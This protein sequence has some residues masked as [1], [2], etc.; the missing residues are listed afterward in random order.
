MDGL[1]MKNSLH[2]YFSL[3]KHWAWMLILVTVLCGGAS[4][5]ISE[6]IPP[7][8]Q[9]ST[10]LI[11]SAYD[12]KL[13]ILVYP[14]PSYYAQL[15]TSPVVL[16][17]VVERHP[18]L[19]LEQLKAMI[20]VKPQPNTQLIELEVDNTNPQRAMQFANEISQS[21][22]QFSNSQLPGTIHVLPAQVSTMHFSAKV[23]LNTMI[24]AL[25]GLGLALALML[26][27]GGT[28]PPHPRDELYQFSA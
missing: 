20:I 14:V 17:P 23:L 22:A 28:Y 13:M 5:G 25:V 24:G 6:A 10:T 16:N 27:F 2:S 8:Y 26:I 7:V 9:A 15:V 3:S 11:V 19:T 18:G 4:F 1:L 12:G 21:F